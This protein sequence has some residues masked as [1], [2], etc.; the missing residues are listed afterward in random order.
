MCCRCFG[1]TRETKILVGTNIT[2]IVIGF[3]YMICASFGS[4]I[5]IN[6]KVPIANDGNF[7][8]AIILLIVSA[9][10]I[11]ATCARNK[12]CLLIYFC[13]LAILC[14][15]Q[16][17]ISI[18]CFSVTR[19]KE[20]KLMEDGWNDC[21]ENL[22]SYI[23]DAEEVFLCCGFD[24]NDYRRNFTNMENRTRIERF[25]CIDRVEDCLREATTVNYQ[26]D[27]NLN[28]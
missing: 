27:E 7:S 1:S 28:F 25:I 15:S 20:E 3:L 23:W 26:F 21:D 11:L 8:C 16:V 10:G 4:I 14:I 24:E 13:A 5:T 9:V 17:S 22:P 19:E 6:G 2:Y 12:L 18:A